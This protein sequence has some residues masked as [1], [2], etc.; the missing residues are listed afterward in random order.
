MSGEYKIGEKVGAWNYWLK[1][2]VLKEQKNY[3]SN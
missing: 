1:D 3:D 2:G